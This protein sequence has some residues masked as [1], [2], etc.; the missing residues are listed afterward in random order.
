M[1]G[2]VVLMPHARRR[3]ALRAQLHSRDLDALLVTDLVNVRY[4][5]GF[6]GSNAALLVDAGG[7][8]H[9]VFCTDGRYD[10]QSR[11]QVP[12]LRRVIERAGDLWLAKEATERG[13]DRWASRATWSRSTR[14]PPWPR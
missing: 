13:V 3:E 12:D 2:S 1:L 5:T 8:E 7:E 9:T 6:T 4:L 14:T 11:R 10:A